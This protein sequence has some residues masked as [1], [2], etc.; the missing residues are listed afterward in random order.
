MKRRDKDNPIFMKKPW[1]KVNRQG[2]EGGEDR[3]NLVGLIG[4]LDEDSRRKMFK[5]KGE[6]TC[7]G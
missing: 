2:I 3:R 5:G 6:A 7:Y 4:D 1:V